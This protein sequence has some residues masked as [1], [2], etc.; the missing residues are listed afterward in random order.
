MNEDNQSCIKM[1]QSDK[2]L[3]RTKHIDIKFHCLRKL[4]EDGALELE[5]CLSN[6]MPAELLT[7]PIPKPAFQK[8]RDKLQIKTLSASEGKTGC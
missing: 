6:E 4:K 8:L 1:T 3:S 5:Y 7:K 2:H